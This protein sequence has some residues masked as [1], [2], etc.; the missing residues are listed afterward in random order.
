MTS[1]ILRFVIFPSRFFGLRIVPALVASMFSIFGA[2]AATQGNWPQYRGPQASGLSAGVATPM[3]W[4]VETGENI[5]WQTNVPGL[6]HSSPIVWGDRV[7]LATA[8][9][10]GKADLKVGLYGDIA[11]ANDQAPHEWRMLAFDKRSGK[12][13][14]NE[15]AHAGIPRVK[16]HTKASHCNSTPATDGRRIV[17]ILGSEGLFCFD[18][19]GRR[20]WHTDLGPM[21]SGYFRSP[22]AQWGFASS[23]VIHDGKAVVL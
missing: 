21:D 20:Q 4:N 6:S 19:Q 1:T 22:T 7:Y 13:I 11:S 10:P 18:M 8:T 23:P 5:L 16:R 9:R 12:P 2:E 14:W 17:A 3:R 15:L